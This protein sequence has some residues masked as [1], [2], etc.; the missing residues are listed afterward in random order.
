MA[1]TSVSN[2][3]LVRENDHGAIFLMVGVEL[4]HKIQDTRLDLNF[5]KA[6]TDAILGACLCQKSIHCLSEIHI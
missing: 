6:P 5:E 1:K 4:P 3:S 2:C